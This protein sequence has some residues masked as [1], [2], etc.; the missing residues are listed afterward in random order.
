MMIT[1]YS[2]VAIGGYNIYIATI[3]KWYIAIATWQY[4]RPGKLD[5][6]FPIS[7]H[8]SQY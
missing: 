3:Y 2:Y 6:L 4:I 5:F 1:S 7:P 8:L